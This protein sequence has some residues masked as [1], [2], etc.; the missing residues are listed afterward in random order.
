MILN[1]VFS[2]NV[3]NGILRGQVIDSENKLPL[4]GANLFINGTDFGTI[5]DTDGYFTVNNIPQDYYTI[6]I[7]YMGYKTKQIVDVWI[8]P[9]AYDF[10]AISLDQTVLNFKNII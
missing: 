10:L 9:N 1:V 7:N 4:S 3:P 2:E 8:R 5:S 6:S